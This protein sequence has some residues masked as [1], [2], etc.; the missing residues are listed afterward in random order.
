LEH[1]WGADDVACAHQIAGPGSSVR[2]G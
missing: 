2:P 1:R